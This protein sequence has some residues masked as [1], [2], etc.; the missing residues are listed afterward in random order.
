MRTLSTIFLA[1]TVTLSTGCRLIQSCSSGHDSTDSPSDSPAGD[2]TNDTFDTAEWA[3]PGEDYTE[4]YGIDMLAYL[5]P[6]TFTMGSDADD[7]ESNEKP[8]HNVTLT[9]AFWLDRSEVTQAQYE[10][11]MGTNPSY[12]PTCPDC[13]V[14]SVSWFEA[15]HF[16]NI[17]S[18]V[19]GFPSCYTDADG[20]GTFVLKDPDPYACAGYRLPTE[21]EWE[22]AASGL[23]DDIYS[24]SNTANDVAWTSDNSGGEVHEVCTLGTNALDFCDFSGNVWELVGDGY[25]D[26]AYPAEDQTDPHGLD[27]GA[28]RINRGGSWHDAPD[29]A[30]VTNRSWDVPTWSA[31]NLGFRVARSVP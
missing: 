24:G 4:S 28:Y 3:A 11:V 22:Y 1:S 6:G 29:A 27:S 26:G 5:G 9:H 17:L 20:N 10:S 13:P 18:N 2:D 12:Y 23:E 25:Q 19:G 7:V 21:A 16:A 8:E 14:D 31:V 30:R 15:A